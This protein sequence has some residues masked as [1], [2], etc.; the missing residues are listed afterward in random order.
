MKRELTCIVCPM[1][2][3]LTVEVEDGRV[4]SVAGNTCPRGA[5]Y[6]ERECIHPERVLTTTV[7]VEGGGVVPVRTDCAVPR[8]KLFDCMEEAN[9][10]KVSLPI[11][12]GDVMIEHIAGTSAN[13][14]ATKNVE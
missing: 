6:A 14:V 10:I 7:A 12:T 11:A 8:E 9:R 3:A 5:A 2:C 1:G 4:M 13:L